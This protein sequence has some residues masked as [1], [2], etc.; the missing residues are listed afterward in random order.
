MVLSHLDGEQGQR[1]GNRFGGNEGGGD[2]ELGY[3]QQPVVAA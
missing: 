3:L 2:N 1:D